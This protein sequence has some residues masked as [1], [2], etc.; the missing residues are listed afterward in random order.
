ML[1]QG[2]GLL[3]VLLLLA[4]CSPVRWTERIDLDD[5]ADIDTVLDERHPIP[6]DSRQ[7]LLLRKNREN[8]G[9]IYVKVNTGREYLRLLANG[10]Y[11]GSTCDMDYESFFIHDTGS[12]VHL[13]Y[14]RPSQRSYVADLRFNEIDPG[15]LPASMLMVGPFPD[16]PIETLSD[17]EPQFEVTSVTPDSIEIIT[18]DM[19][20][21]FELLAW[22]D[23]DWDGY[24]D[25]L[26]TYAY[27]YLKGTGRSYGHAFLTRRSENGELVSGEWEEV[28]KGR[29]CPAF[30]GGMP[31]LEREMD[32]GIRL[33]A[34]PD[35][36]DV[37]YSL[38]IRW[39]DQLPW[40]SPD[41]SYLGSSAWLPAESL[42]P[43]TSIDMACDG[44]KVTAAS[45]QE[46]FH[47]MLEGFRPEI[48]CNAS[49]RTNGSFVRFVYPQF[50]LRQAV[51]AKTSC[52]T[53]FALSESLLREL[54]PTLGLFACPS[55]E[56]DRVREIESNGGTWIDAYPDSTVKV[57]TAHHATVSG[58]GSR[59]VIRLLAWGDFDGDDEE[60]VLLWFWRECTEGTYV[61]YDVVALTR[62]G[63]DERL[64]VIAWA[65]DFGP[66]AMAEPNGDERLEEDRDTLILEPCD[67]Q[68]PSTSSYGDELFEEPGDA[69]QMSTAPDGRIG[70]E[71]FDR[72]LND[73]NVSA[74][75]IKQAIE[76][77]GITE[78]AVW[79]QVFKIALEVE[80]A[81][82]LKNYEKKDIDRSQ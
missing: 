36:E 42:T 71:E 12:L 9:T 10:Y 28:K 18:G 5:L 55:E 46:Y 17:F 37:R 50:Y 81:R 52:L 34:D 76:E 31:R 47:L 40:L 15:K 27:Y 8:G 53:D 74:E 44:R 63:A 33:C 54:P 32:A 6:D 59:V 11:V 67:L 21:T 79:Y 77:R 39:T 64:E 57:H 45:P 49:F 69:D 22:G 75:E 38:P 62:R 2:K 29:Y 23:F 43:G 72:W 82:R 48:S 35:C 13:S 7:R 78:D 16:R 1:G 68:E 66:E 25:V 73:P 60:D 70:V 24:E 4:G 80:E 56:V 30:F 26:L 41:L 51:S 65:P 61:D 14:A 19:K 20:H 58:P 3:V